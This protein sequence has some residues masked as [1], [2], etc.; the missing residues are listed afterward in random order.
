MPMQPQT[1]L[2]GANANTAVPQPMGAPQQTN[3]YNGASTQ[4]PPELNP[5]KMGNQTQQLQQKGMPTAQ[6]V[7]KAAHNP[8][9]KY[10]SGGIVSPPTPEQLDNTNSKFDPKVLAATEEAVKDETA[11]KNQKGDMESEANP[12][13]FHD[14]VSPS[15]KEM[16]DMFDSL[17]PVQ[18]KAKGGDVHSNIKNMPLKDVIK[19]LASHP[20][21]GGMG[22]GNGNSPITGPQMAAGGAVAGQNQPDAMPKKVANMKREA[23]GHGAGLLNMNADVQTYAQGGKVTDPVMPTY[24]PQVAAGSLP[25]Q[26]QPSGSVGMASGG[27]LEGDTESDNITGYGPDGTPIIQNADGTSQYGDIN[28]LLGR[29]ESASTLGTGAA[30]ATGVTENAANSVAGAEATP[31]QMAKGGEEGPPPGALSKEVADDVPAKLSEGEFVFSADVVRYY[32]LR[33]LNGM[34]EHAR[35]SLTDMENEGNIRSPGD[36]KNPAA[37]SQGSMASFMQDAKP[38]M[39]AYDEDGGNK[40]EQPH[41]QTDPDD[42]TGILKECMGGGMKQGGMCYS[43]GGKVDAEENSLAKGGPVKQPMPMGRDNMVSSHPKGGGTLMDYAK[44]GIVG[45]TSIS[46][47]PK[48][49]NSDIPSAAAKI[50]KPSGIEIPKIHSKPIG[51]PHMSKGGA[52]QTMQSPQQKQP[53]KA[54]KPQGMQVKNMMPPIV[55]TQSLIGS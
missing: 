45:S 29:P 36:G 47:T 42:P 50:S 27:G 30:P 51:L 4:P 55:P 19:L 52:M 22:A 32:G 2:M 31:N 53:M 34:M 46:L 20:D 5:Y 37:N 11:L 24:Q 18:N 54:P 39:N 44:G 33:L 40:G 41:D 9:N 17:Q 12:G 16:L 14:K 26:Q 15:D 13:A 43:E 1:S 49:L 7:N 38:N 21:V 6:A 8:N 25:P 23:R 35:Q 48:K 3:P 10:A 28:S